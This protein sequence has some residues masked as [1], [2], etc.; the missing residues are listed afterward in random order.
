M[1]IL[2]TYGDLV[3]LTMLIGRDL[4]LPGDL[5]N[6]C[7]LHAVS[8]SS[9]ASDSVYSFR[10]GDRFTTIDYILTDVEAYSCVDQCWTHDDDDLN[11]SDHLPLSVKL[12]CSVTTQQA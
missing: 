5:L 12:A 1:N 6:R 4:I 9:T 11:Q 7:E 8:L 3:P 2:A 10:S